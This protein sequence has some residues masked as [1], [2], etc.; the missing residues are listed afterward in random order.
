[1]QVPKWN[2][3]KVLLWLN[4]IFCPLLTA[5]FV[6][7]FV[8]L[9][10]E[11]GV[12]KRSTQQQLKM[13][14]DA[15]M[16]L[17]QVVVTAVNETLTLNNTVNEA[18][19]TMQDDVQTVKE[20]VSGRVL[21]QGAATFMVLCIMVFLYHLTSHL[22]HMH[23]PLVQRK[24]MAVLWMTPIYGA[25]ALMSLVLDSPTASEYLAVIKDFY[26]A[27]CI[28][29]FLSLLIAILGRGDRDEAVDVL[30]ARADHMKPPIYL[31]GWS[32]FL[33][34]RKYESNPRGK[35]DAILYQCQFCAMQFVLFRPITSVGI[36]VSNQAMGTDWGYASPQ[37]VFLI[38]TNVS[39][40]FALSGLVCFSH[41]AREPLAWVNPFPKFLCIKGVVFMTFWQGMV[42]TLLA[43]F[44]YRVEDPIDWSRR[45]QNFVICLE[46][47]FFAIGHCFVFPTD[48]WAPGY[49]PRVRAHKQKFGDGIALRDFVK[50]VKLLVKTRKGTRVRRS[51]KGAGP[52]SDVS[53]MASTMPS[54]PGG[55]EAP[56]E[57]EEHSLHLQD[58][59][60]MSLGDTGH[61]SSGSDDAG[62]DREGDY[63]II[64]RTRGQ[65]RVMGP[66]GDSVPLPIDMVRLQES[67]EG[68]TM[69]QQADSPHAQNGGGDQSVRAHA[70]DGELI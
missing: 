47:L 15:I 1:M 11:V 45:I 52:Y 16:S 8:Y 54:M 68:G 38:I 48:E 50:D 51:S 31:C 7:F 14:E 40:F 33:N 64:Y 17:R 32:P 19:E 46:M 4:A 35:A 27:Y 70:E 22:R 23:N 36:A 57:S 66:D 59:D 41:A 43:K 12:E 62:D 6:T 60:G 55:V 53:T 3:Q 44:V 18:Q 29:T 61:G 20:Q 49:Q 9:Q 39:I 24:I 69:F 58:E 30:A 42:I 21:V 63:I 67:L 25:T 37:F 65:T 5:L 28:Y 26:E 13:Q 2:T 56:F 34:L 10:R